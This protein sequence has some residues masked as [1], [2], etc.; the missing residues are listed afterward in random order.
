[1]SSRSADTSIDADSI[2]V[3]RRGLE[4][5]HHVRVHFHILQQNPCNSC[6]ID[7]TGFC[8]GLLRPWKIIDLR[9]LRPGVG[10][11]APPDAMGVLP[12]LSQSDAGDVQCLLGRQAILAKSFL[13]KK[14]VSSSFIVENDFWS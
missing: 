6:S 5:L 10:R 14:V 9:I 1:M 3:V 11:G 8:S 2:Q 13:S 12:A 4:N 7:L